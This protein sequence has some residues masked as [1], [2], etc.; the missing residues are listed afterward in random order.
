ME[1]RQTCYYG[2]LYDEN[3]RFLLS[4]YPF[5]ETSHIVDTHGQPL[6]PQKQRGL[7]P[8]ASRFVVERVE[9]PHGWAMLKRMLVSPRFNPWVYLRITPEQ[10]NMPLFVWVLPADLPDEPSME[11]A[12]LAALG[13][14]GSVSGWLGTLRPTFVA[15]IAHKQI[16][17]GMGVAELTAARGAPHRWFVDTLAGKQAQ[18]AW[19]ADQEAWLVDDAVA[20]ITKGRAPPAQQP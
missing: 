8:A 14:D 1:L 17:A 9:F 20:K 5:A 2:D 6:H 7:L 10:P 4:P 16:V 11:A 15:A 12:L 13:P 19:Y 18:V 3:Q